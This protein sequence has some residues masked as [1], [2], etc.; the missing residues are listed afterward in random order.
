[1]SKDFQ[2]LILQGAGASGSLVG[3]TG[4]I[5]VSGNFGGGD[6]TLSMTGDDSNAPYVVFTSVMA[7]DAQYVRAE[8]LTFTSSGNASTDLSIKWFPVREPY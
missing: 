6:V 5:S 3:T 1:M 2:E 8:R 7:N 4:V